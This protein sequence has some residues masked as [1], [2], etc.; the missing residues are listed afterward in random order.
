MNGALNYFLTNFLQVD[1]LS[2]KENLLELFKH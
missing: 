2:L 1:I